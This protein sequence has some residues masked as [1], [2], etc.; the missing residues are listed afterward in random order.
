[1]EGGTSEAA[2]VSAQTVAHAVEDQLGVV[3]PRLDVQQESGKAHPNVPG[4]YSVQS[5][6]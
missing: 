3:Q 2:D 1:M 5:T 4:V 6:I